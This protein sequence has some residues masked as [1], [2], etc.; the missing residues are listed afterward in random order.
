M[1][2]RDKSAYLGFERFGGQRV[3]GVGGMC[4]APLI[5]TGGEIQTEQK[6]CEGDNNN[7]NVFCLYGSDRPEAKWVTV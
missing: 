3:W 2:K 6:Q 4:C 1:S 7:D 5:G